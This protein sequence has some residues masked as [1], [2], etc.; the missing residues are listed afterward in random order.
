MRDIKKYSAWD[1]LEYLSETNNKE[2]LDNL[3]V[4]KQ[5]GQRKQLWMHRFNDEVIR[6]EKMF[7]TKLKYIH[8]NPVKAGLVTKSEDYKYSSAISYVEGK[9]YLLKIDR[10][11][12]GIE[13]VD[14]IK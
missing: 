5:P 2:L 14:F 7:W 13:L 1:I 11:F 8:Q 3:G 6:N 12:V 4:P 10:D 9:D